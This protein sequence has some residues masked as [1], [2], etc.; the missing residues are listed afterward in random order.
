[1]T[2]PVRAITLAR[3]MA[4]LVAV[5]AKRIETRPQATRYRGPLAIHAAAAPYALT[6]PYHRQV[7]SESGLDP[8]RLPGCAVIAFCRLVDCRAITP[9][10]C[11]CY[12][13]YAFGQFTPGWY[14]WLLSGVR[15]LEKPVPARGRAGLWRWNPPDH[16]L[17]KTE[18]G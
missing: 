16:L 12:P 17:E 11:P 2:D 3:P 10:Q 6:D 7:L 8:D 14:A 13:E 18:D 5:G 1:M 15:M 4:W 9:A